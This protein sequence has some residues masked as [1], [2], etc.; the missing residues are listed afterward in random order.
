MSSRRVLQRQIMP[1]GRDLDVL[2][3]YVDPNPAFDDGVPTDGSASKEL[4]AA[5]EIMAR[6][7]TT[8]GEQV[9]PDQIL[10]RTTF[11]LSHGE[12]ISFASYFNAFPASYWRRWSVVDNVR[13][14]VSV[15][16][17][18]ATVIVYKSMANGRTQRVDTAEID[19][20]GTHTVS[21]ELSLKPFIDGGWYWY[22]VV[23]GDMDVDVS[24][25]WDAEVPDDKVHHGTVDICITTMNR[26]EDC[27]KL[28][29]Q[30][31]EDDALRPY[32]D[33]VMVMDQGTQLVGDN[34]YY[35]EAAAALG[36]KLKMLIQGNLGG[37]GGFARGQYESVKKGTARYMMCLDDDVVS[38]PEGVVRA[39]TFGDLARRPTL[40]GGHMFSMYARANLHSFG[41]VLQPWRFWWT[42]AG[43]VEDDWDFSVRNLRASKW[44]HR[45]VDVDYNGWW[46]CLIPTQVLRDIG[47]SL[48]LFI[49]WDD[50][51]YSIRARS[52][53]YP[54]VSFPGAAVWHVPW[55]DKNDALDWQA[56]Y[57][58]RNRFVAALLHSVYPRGG[59]MVAESFN[60]QIKHLVSMQYS[61]VAMRHQ[62]LLDIL[63]G[64]EHLHRTLATRRD[65]MQQ[66]RKEY[67]DAQLET[68]R[69]SFPPAR[70]HKPPRRGKDSLE[71]GNP[72][73]AAIKAGLAPVKALRS[74]RPTAKQNPEIDLA[75]M[76]AK[77]WSISKFDSVVVSMPD[78]TSAAMYQRDPDTFKQMAA[79]TVEIHKRLAQE[80][81]ELAQRYR[82]ALDEVASP[83]AWEQTLAPYLEDEDDDF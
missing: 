43:G 39:I 30:L 76:D 2:P 19:T 73:K 81:P 21:F 8:G 52:A 74:P 78:G 6:N 77:W 10:D 70:R 69:E 23:A 62:A 12:R 9:H 75:A 53:G 41:E 67:V 68:D 7:P 5:A 34:E 71:L 40:V 33:S 49:K 79:R 16:G 32:L 57:H 4:K 28:L 47:L 20:P 83:A 42:S 65:D 56:Y 35:P 26:G 63:E 72:V 64:P 48:P 82:D 25:F 55:T 14:N 15:N 17:V 27:A 31:G 51:E 44:L 50:L 29:R 18:G 66:L 13:L 1:E 38:E 46:M 3:L 22:D 59:R 36:D 54:T 58:Q 24:A 11:R 60:H 80:W 45:R 37:S 61:T